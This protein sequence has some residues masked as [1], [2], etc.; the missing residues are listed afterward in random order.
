[1]GE[2]KI[3]FSSVIFQ[4]EDTGGFLNK[5]EMRDNNEPFNF[6]VREFSLQILHEP[7][8]ISANGFFTVNLDL[9]GSVSALDSTF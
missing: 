5:I 1:M 8:I 6:L 4:A 3:S 2:K 9:L 7:I